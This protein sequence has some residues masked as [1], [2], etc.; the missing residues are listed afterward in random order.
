MRWSG[1]LSPRILWGK[2][3]PGFR[4]ME[5]RKTAVERAFE[6][7]RSGRCLS[8]RDVAFKLHAENFDITHLEGPVLRKQLSELIDEALKPKGKGA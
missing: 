6:L 8:I 3:A 5:H 4:S 7:A 1:G 2:M